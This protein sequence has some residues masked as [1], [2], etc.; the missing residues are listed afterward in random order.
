MHLTR[1]LPIAVLQI[2]PFI[3]SRSPTHPVCSA[4][5]IAYARCQRGIRHQQQYACVTQGPEPNSYPNSDPTPSLTPSLI[6]RAP[7]ATPLQGSLT[8]LLPIV[9]M[10][11]APTAQRVLESMLPHEHKM[12]CDD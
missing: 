5:R 3:A 12:P 7:R 2:V 8:Y 10:V 1:T 6:P 11:H 4:L 9:H